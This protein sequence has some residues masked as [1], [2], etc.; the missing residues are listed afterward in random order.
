MS[1][2]N[3][4]QNPVDFDLRTRIAAVQR[5]HMGDP[6]E[7]D[8]GECPCGF[9]YSTTTELAAH[10]A[11]MVIRELGRYEYAIATSDMRFICMYVDDRSEL[12]GL[13][14]HPDER[15]V[16]RYVTEWE[17]DDE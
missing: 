7:Q 13:K 11:D 17:A 1:E 16:R 4:S 10:I 9:R 5:A 15:I 8:M 14:L 2:S 3:E 6:Y 12:D